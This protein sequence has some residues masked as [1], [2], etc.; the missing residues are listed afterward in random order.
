MYRVTQGTFRTPRGQTPTLSYREDTNDWNVLISCLNE[1][2]Y[3][4]KELKL[5]GTALDIGAH[6]GGVT[7]ALALDNPELKVI[8]VEAVPPNVELLRENV[9]LAGVEDRVTILHAA[10]G[11]GKT[12]TV[13][14]AFEGNYVADHHAFI[15]NAVMPDTTT[16]GT[17]ELLDVVTLTALAKEYGP[18]SFAK[19]DCEGCEYD[20]LK[21]R[22]LLDIACI[23]GEEHY[24]RLPLPGFDVTYTQDNAPRGF[25]A[26]RRG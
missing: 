25:T 21:G 18:F 17:S 9:R 13:R 3:D 6:I 10:A 11:K 16:A 12:A 22:G 5:S 15:G 4:L 1:D 26:V 8:A 24:G 2:E 23:R 20:F 19:V 7:I 14:W